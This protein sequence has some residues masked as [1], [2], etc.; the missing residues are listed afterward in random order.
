VDIPEGESEAQATSA[1]MLP[2]FWQ[3]L[4]HSHAIAHYRIR[5]K[6]RIA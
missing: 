6:A 2:R 4:R 1:Q 5:M 3:V